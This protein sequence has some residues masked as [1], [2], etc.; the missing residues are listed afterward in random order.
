VVIE[1]ILPRIQT[2]LSTFINE[3]IERAE[4]NVNMN[5]FVTNVVHPYEWTMDL[6]EEDDIDM[7]SDETLEKHR[8]ETIPKIVYNIDQEL[9]EII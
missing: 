5:N 8:K 6:K 4:R 3:D 9:K 2:Y 7:A 1:N